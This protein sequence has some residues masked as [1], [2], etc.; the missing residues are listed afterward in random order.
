MGIGGL[1]PNNLVAAAL[2]PQPVQVKDLQAE[3]F[4]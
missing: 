4:S 1:L 3:G 2:P